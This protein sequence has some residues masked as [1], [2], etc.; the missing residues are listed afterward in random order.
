MKKLLVL[1]PVYGRHN[2]LR[3]FGNG[4]DVLKYKGYDID[5][6]AVGSSEVDKM[7]CNELNFKYVHHRNILGEK[8][9]H[10][11]NYS[12]QFTFDAMLMLGSDDLINYAAIDFIIE[13]LKNGDKFIGFLDC[14]FYDLLNAKLIKWNGYGEPKRLGEP[15]GAWRCFSREML[16]EQ[17]WRLWHDRHTHIDLSMW[18][19]ISHLDGVNTYKMAP[20]IMICDMKSDVNVN[21]FNVMQHM[22]TENVDVD[23]LHLFN[24]DTLYNNILKFNN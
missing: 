15:I 22:N 21:K 13:R 1:V 3:L 7:V 4:I 17:D 24:D 16:E 19:K 2:V 18:S 9:N 5:V 10:A 23:L 11:L 12:R 6:L 8:L 14:Y 20:D